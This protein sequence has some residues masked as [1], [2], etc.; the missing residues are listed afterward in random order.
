VAAGWELDTQGISHADLIT[1]GP[2]RVGERDGDPNVHP[3]ISGARSRKNLYNA[4]AL[5]LAIVRGGPSRRKDM[6]PLPA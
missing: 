3:C 4:C 6:K 5:D 1:S 2:S